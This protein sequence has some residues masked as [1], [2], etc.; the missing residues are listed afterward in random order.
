MLKPI[1]SFTLDAG[2]ML[3]SCIDEKN[4]VANHSQQQQQ[5]EQ[6]QQQQQLRT[7]ATMSALH[8]VGL[9]LD[10]RSSGVRPIRSVILFAI[11]ERHLRPLL[12]PA[13]LIA[14]IAAT[15]IVSLQV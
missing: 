12:L 7:L 3:S 15:E 10:I 4:G 8:C 9:I 1:L 2:F 11:L 13:I 5:Q 6:Q 14:L